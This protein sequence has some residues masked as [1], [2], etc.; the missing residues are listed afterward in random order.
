MP[1]Q[2]AMTYAVLSSPAAVGS[3]VRVAA[4]ECSR[5]VE[6]L[7]LV[8]DPRQPRGV[9]HTVAGLLAVAA[10]AVLSGARSVLAVGEWAGEAPQAVLAAL[11]ARFCVRRGRY[12]SAHVDTFRRVLEQVNA[13]AV[14]A[15]IGL[16]LAERAGAG[17]LFAGKPST[18]TDAAG[19]AH[20][21]PESQPGEPASGQPAAPAGQQRDQRPVVGVL[22]VDGKQ[23]RGARQPD[24]KAVHLLSA[25]LHEQRAVV[26]QRDVAHKTNEITQVRPLLEP[27]DL[28]GW[29]VTVDA[30]HVQKDTARY[31]V[32]DKQAAYVFTAV[33]DNQPNLFAALDELAWK[34]APV[35]HQCWHRGHGRL[36][37]RTIQV[38]PAPPGGFPHAAQA[39]LIERY[40]YDPH[41]TQRLVSAASSLGITSLPARLAGPAQLATYVRG[42]WGIESL[43]WIRDVTFD[44]DRHQLRTGSAPQILAGLR[45]LAIGALR[46]AGR[47]K[48]AAG[49]R[50]VSRNPL[51]V[52]DILNQPT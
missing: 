52:L 17:G 16:F 27:L 26:A 18:G 19:G 22:A 10:A 6:L 5:L 23:A 30:M 8:P 38:L 50:W 3:R 28:S 41:N 40:V 48:I 15:A 31:L 32:E 1:S 46:T 9:R 11:G 24:G 51:R 2:S 13:A 35:A 36:E 7:S 49:L 44:E 42:H 47:T 12:A 43:H 14:D 37:E 4:G 39:F 45:N 29:V 20:Q 25:M 33:K 34:Q 21:Q